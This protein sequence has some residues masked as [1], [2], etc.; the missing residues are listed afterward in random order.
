[1][2]TGPIE[3]KKDAKDSEAIEISYKI[4][5][6]IFEIFSALC[7]V[8]TA[9]YD[10]M[11]AVLS[12]I[13]DEQYRFERL[14][15]SLHDLGVTHSS[16]EKKVVGN[17]S[18][19][20]EEQQEPLAFDCAAAALSMFNNIVHTPDTVEKRNALRSEL[21]RRGFEELIRCLYQKR[22]MLP[23]ALEEQVTIYLQQKRLD[24]EKSS[25]MEKNK[26]QSILQL[27]P[28]DMVASALNF[29]SQ[30]PELYCLVVDSISE[31]ITIGSDQISTNRNFVQDIWNIV[32]LFS[33]SL[34]SL[35]NENQFQTM[36]QQFMVSIQPIVGKISEKEQREISIDHATTSATATSNS[37]NSEDIEG[38]RNMVDELKDNFIR[39]QDAATKIRREKNELLMKMSKVLADVKE[40][41]DRIAALEAEVKQGKSSEQKSTNNIGSS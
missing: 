22:H 32:N 30:D 38:L 8:S 24:Q 10:A 35:H 40:R 17:F 26:R 6:I 1:M 12:Q 29:F 39:S 33:K 31:I 28:S 11:I 2:H 7:L 19:L 18:T 4:C 14:V 23:N 15:Q 34:K 37:N 5:I 36:L 9:G 13:K 20:I 21:E 25:A 27:Q 3:Y 16:T 41:D